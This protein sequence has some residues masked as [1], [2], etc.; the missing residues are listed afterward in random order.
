M[1]SENEERI[2]GSEDQTQNFS[3]FFSTEF[4]IAII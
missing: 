2:R 3:T 1:A 4:N